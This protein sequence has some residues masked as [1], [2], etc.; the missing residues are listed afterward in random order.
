M[1]A[2]LALRGAIGNGPHDEPHEDKLEKVRLEML[3]RAEQF[4]QNREVAEASVKLFGSFEQTAKGMIPAAPI[5]SARKRS[6]AA[7][8]KSIN[9]LIDVSWAEEDEKEAE[10]ENI[11]EERRKFLQ[12]YEEWVKSGSPLDASAL[13]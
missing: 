1:I 6:Y 2:R 13:K 5:T 11:E 3:I 12:E 10:P 8:I 4:D 9:P 7:L